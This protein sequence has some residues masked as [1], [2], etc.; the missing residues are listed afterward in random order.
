MGGPLER[1]ADN[2]RPPFPLAAML[3]DRRAGLFAG[4]LFFGP[5]FS[6][7]PKTGRGADAD[8]L[9][10]GV[11]VLLDDATSLSISMSVSVVYAL[12][13]VMELNYLYDYEEG[14]ILLNIGK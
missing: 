10:E 7:G 14:K 1:S 13:Y 2:G 11:R 4:L 3:T 12:A 9:F 8:H 5:P 6:K